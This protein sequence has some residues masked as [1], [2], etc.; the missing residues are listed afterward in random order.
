MERNNNNKSTSS[1]FGRMSARASFISK[2]ELKVTVQLLNDADTIN[3]EFKKSATGKDVLDYVCEFLNITEKD[4]FGLR[5]QDHHRH[6][7]WVDLTQSLSS[8]AKLFKSD[9]LAFRLR[10]RYYPSSAAQ[11]REEITRYQLNV[12][13]QRDLLH[14]R[15]YCPAPVAAQLAAY[16]LQSQVGD[17]PDEEGAR[18]VSEYKLLLKQ[19]PKVEEKIAEL[20]KGLRGSSAAEAE[21]RMIEMACQMETYGFDPYTVKDPKNNAISVYIGATHRGI[22][23]FHGSQKAHHMQWSEV[24]K[25]DYTG[26]ELRIYPC[27]GYEPM[28]ELEN[29]VAGNGQAHNSTLNQTHTSESMMMA[30]HTDLD[31][32]NETSMMEKSVK[33]TPTKMLRYLCPS[34]TFAKHLWVH[35]LSQKTFF[36]ETTSEGIK[37][38]FSKP[39]IPLFTRGS[40]FRFPAQRVL[41][42]IETSPVEER[43]PFP[44]ARYE[45][46]KQTARSEM[47]AMTKYQTLP[48]IKLNGHLRNGSAGGGAKSPVSSPTEEKKNEVFM[49]EATTAT[50]SASSPASPPTVISTVTTTIGGGATQSNGGANVSV[51]SVHLVKTEGTASSCSSTHTTTPFRPRITTEPLRDRSPAALA[52]AVSQP[53]QEEN[54][55]WQKHLL[56]NS[57]AGTI[58]EPIAT[59]TPKASELT[60]RRVGGANGTNDANGTKAEEKKGKQVRF[61]V[62]EKPRASS[63]STSSSSSSMGRRLVNVAFVMFLLLLI[64]VF[65][66]IVLFERQESATFVESQP[67]LVNVRRA[68]Y[69][70]IKEVALQKYNAAFAR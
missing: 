48:N 17:A 64:L 68:Y 16:I 49:D 23:V 61:T 44:F 15:L 29:G 67:W 47:P 1:L 13:L 54:N 7:Y 18:Y 58:G 57:P 36:N 25:I 60:K 51:I 8:L 4:Y 56:T 43:A 69:E 27:E 41:K 66:T 22:L 28:V 20:H 50:A 39:R 63:V 53:Q 33:A 42:E 21:L 59:S 38:L 12:Q 46:P 37:P 62:D 65:T 70:P 31:K 52:T 26:N 40:T 5:Y 30:N 45:L 10:F 35:L 9:N 3:T 11:L 2:K 14:G 55:N 34:R 19:T 6:R 32:E 24:T